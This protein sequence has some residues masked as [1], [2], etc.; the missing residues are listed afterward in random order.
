[1]P[2]LSVTKT[3]TTTANF[4]NADPASIGPW[5]SPSSGA[6]ED[7][8][9]AS[10]KLNAF[11]QTDFLGSAGYS[12]FG[13]P[14]YARIDGVL[15]QVLMQ[16]DVP[17]STQITEAYLTAPNGTISSSANSAGKPISGSYGWGE[18]GTEI[19]GATD[20]WGMT[21]AQLQTWLGAKNAGFMFKVEEI[22]GGVTLVEVDAVRLTVYY[23]LP[24]RLGIMGVGA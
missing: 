13:I 10:A 23:Y 22:V 9:F 24:S 12:G 7:S 14:A 11:E 8:I 4:T 15:A 3:C 19:G 20:K 6:V 5:T 2:Y 1:M 17:D 18:K 21:N 16:A